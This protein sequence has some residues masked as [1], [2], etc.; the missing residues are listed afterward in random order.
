MSRHELLQR[1]LSTGV[2][3]VIR[4]QDAGRARKAIDALL[5]GGIAAVEI[6]MTVPDAPALI[7]ELRRTCDPGVLIGAGTVVGADSARLVIDAGAQFLVSPI[8]ETAVLDAG[9]AAHLPVIPGCFT[10]AEIH[11]AWS[12]AA[13]IVKVFPSAVLGPRF[14]RDV[15]GPFPGIRMMPTG[16]VTIDNVGEWVAAGA[17]A[18]GVGGDL[19]AKELV[20]REDYP[21]LTERA[22]KLVENFRKARG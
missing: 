1:I 7:A 21:A 18:V 19:I 6:T 11:T 20:D 9:H 5:R 17:C 10:P 12:A 8:F 13:D 14:F 2:V 15:R 16:G 22:E 4:M 3:A